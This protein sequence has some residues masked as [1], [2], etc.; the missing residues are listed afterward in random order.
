MKSYYAV[1][2]PSE[3]MTGRVPTGILLGISSPDWSQGSSFSKGLPGAVC[4]K[5]SQHSGGCDREMNRSYDG[6]I[7]AFSTTETNVT[8]SPNVGRKSLLFIL[9]LLSKGLLGFGYS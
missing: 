4:S 8:L 1:T 9:L 5:A 7:E 6:D 3:K 2:L